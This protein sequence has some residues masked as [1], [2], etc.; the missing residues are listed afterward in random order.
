MTTVSDYLGTLGVNASVLA[1]D[2][3]ALRADPVAMRAFTNLECLRLE[4]EIQ[5][6]RK[7][8]STVR[9]YAPCQCAFYEG[10]EGEPCMLGRDDRHKFTRETDCHCH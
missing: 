5:D 6:F 4:Q 3:D 7:R 8:I 9:A 1:T 10:H 2:I